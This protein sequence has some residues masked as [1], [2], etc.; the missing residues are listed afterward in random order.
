MGVSVFDGNIATPG[1]G[2]LI[3]PLIGER[4]VEYLTANRE[5]LERLLMPLMA[6]QN[7]L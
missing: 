3:L 7:S 2:L 4:R 1:Q 5:G 6:S